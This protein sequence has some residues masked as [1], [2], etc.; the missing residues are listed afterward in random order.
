MRIKG[1]N[2]ETE[3]HGKIVYYFWK[4]IDYYSYF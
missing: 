2:G 1:G 3:A 4:R